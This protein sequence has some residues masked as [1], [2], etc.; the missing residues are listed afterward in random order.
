MPPIKT[1][2]VWQNLISQVFAEDIEFDPEAVQR[3][4]V[5]NLVQRTL[6]H[7]VGQGKKKGIPIRATE[8]GALVVAMTGLAFEDSKVSSATFTDD[9]A[10]QIV[11]THVVSRIDV[12][13]WTNPVLM[14]L[15]PDGTRWG[16]WI[17][18]NADSEYSLDCAVSKLEI[19]NKTPGSN[20]RYQL[21]GW[22]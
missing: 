4:F 5:N 9:D 16:D 8:A 17:E 11:Y 3:F 21:V 18:R 7:L 1:T 14:R 6:A 22:Y 12:T 20:A 13:I 2:E 10:D 19:K 15:S